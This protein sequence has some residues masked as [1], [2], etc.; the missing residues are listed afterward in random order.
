MRVSDLTALLK[1][2][3]EINAEIALMVNVKQTADPTLTLK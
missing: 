2:Q 3:F 1:K